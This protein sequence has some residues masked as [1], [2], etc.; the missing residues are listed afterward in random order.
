[1]SP[2][3]GARHVRTG[4]V[5]ALVIAWLVR[6]WYIVLL[7]SYAYSWDMSCWEEIAQFIG[8]GTNP[9]M[10][11]TSLSWPPF[12]LMCLFVLD[13][14]AEAGSVAFLDVLRAFLLVVESIGLVLAWLLARRTASGTNATKVL[15]YGLALNP[16]AILLTCQH[17]NF[18][19]LVSLWVMAFLLALLAYLRTKEPMDWLLACLFL[20]LGVMTK[21]VP[22]ALAPLLMPGAKVMTRKARMVGAALFAGPSAVGLGVLFALA[23]ESIIE[24]VLLYSPVPGRFGFS[25]IATILGIPEAIP[26]LGRI[27]SFTILALIG[28]GCAKAWSWENVRESQVVLLAG[29]ILL[30]IPTLGP[31]FGPQ[32]AFWFLAP[33]AVSYLSGSVRWKVTLVA[34]Y[35]VTAVTYVLLYGFAWDLGQSIFFL[36]DSPH[37]RWLGAA[38]R[39]N[40][41]RA[42]VTLPMFVSWLGLLAAGFLEFRAQAAEERVSA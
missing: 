25:G 10:T 11:T 6:G 9:Y 1:M 12:W 18:D 5:F 36:W 42:W 28:W 31:G 19:S 15:L 22:F 27:C 24:R 21:T 8:S 30:A 41:P 2:G 40:A 14:I 16:I 33:L 20:G 23:P 39:H 4:L 35:V 29:L 3:V 34:V 38:L 32:Y 37:A 7:P 26:T 13:R 17:G